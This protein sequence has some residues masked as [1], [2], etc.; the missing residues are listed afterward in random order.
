M[1]TFLAG[2]PREIF[3]AGALRD[4]EGLGETFSV[5]P[6]REA[7]GARDFLAG[8]LRDTEAQGSR[9]TFSA[10]P[11]RETEGS[12]IGRVSVAGVLDCSTPPPDSPTMTDITRRASCLSAW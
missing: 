6:P 1:E 10:G 9:E 7:E 5:W 3:L 12:G 2:A 11:P 8:A 4:T